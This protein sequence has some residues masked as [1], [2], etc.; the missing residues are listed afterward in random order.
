MKRCRKF[1]GLFFVSL[2]FVFGSKLNGKS[3][4]NIIEILNPCRVSMVLESHSFGIVSLS[5]NILQT[6]LKAGQ[7]L[8]D[9]LL[10]G[11]TKNETTLGFF[12]NLPWYLCVNHGTKKDACGGP[13]DFLIER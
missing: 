8:T 6:L 11:R 5:A 3:S 9:C 4:T 10:T 13:R 2:A 1:V 12:Q 7:S